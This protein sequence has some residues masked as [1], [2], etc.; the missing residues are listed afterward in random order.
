MCFG[1]RCN[2]VCVCVYAC[3]C[4]RVCVRGGN[5]SGQGVD[6]TVTLSSDS[7]PSCSSR[8]PCQ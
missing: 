2:N 6:T 8:L 3:V 5:T 7:P 1:T 4:M